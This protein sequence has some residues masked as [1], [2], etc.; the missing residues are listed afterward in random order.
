MA[1]PYPVAEVLSLVL[2]TCAA[3]P[4]ATDAEAYYRALGWTP[5][6]ESSHPDAHN[7]ANWQAAAARNPAVD[8]PSFVTVL[9]QRLGGEALYA[10]V[11]L[12]YE[13]GKP[14]NSCS[15]IDY[16]ETRKLPP[17]KVADILGAA[18]PA[19][20]ETHGQEANWFDLPHAPSAQQLMVKYFRPN[21]ASHLTGIQFYTS[22]EGD[23][24]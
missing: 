21:E 14:A 20:T 3:L 4:S 10:I 18:V 13:A 22:Y 6:T 2:D 8:A 11:A 17:A 1:E 12:T 23:E 19:A 9:E 7:S 15:V 5:L 24:I 16:D